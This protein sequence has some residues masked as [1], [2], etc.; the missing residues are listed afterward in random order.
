[1]AIRHILYLVVLSAFSRAAPLHGQ[2]QPLLA[3]LHVPPVA[4]NDLLNNTYLVM[5]KDDVPP[6]AFKSHMQ[7]LTAAS[8]MFPL[9][10]SGDGVRLEHI[11]DSVVAKGY[12]GTFSE[13]TVEMIRRRPEVKYVEQD[14]IIRPDTVRVQ[15]NPTWVG[16]PH[17]WY[18]IRVR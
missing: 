15:R 9:H 5:F 2:S 3:P 7:F 16:I 17:V 12:S 1:M 6:F 10:K 11:Y 14:Q 13:G 18:F 8:E 4:Q